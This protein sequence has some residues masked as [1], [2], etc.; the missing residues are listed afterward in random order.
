M[1]VTE[2]LQGENAACKLTCLGMRVARGVGG[3]SG[4][5]GGW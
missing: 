5:Q 4:R 2:A 3:Q 1:G